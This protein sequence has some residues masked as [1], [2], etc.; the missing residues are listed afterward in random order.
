MN[1]SVIISASKIKTL[2]NDRFSRK[3]IEQRNALTSRI[4]DATKTMVGFPEPLEAEPSEEQVKEYNAKCATFRK[5][6]RTRLTAFN[7]IDDEIKTL[8]E[9]LEKSDDDSAKEKIK[10]SIQ[11]QEKLRQ[12]L[13]N[14]VSVEVR[15]TEKKVFDL[16]SQR[17]AVASR[18]PHI[19]KN[20][21][22]VLSLFVGDIAQ[23]FFRNAIHNT[24]RAKRKTVTCEDMFGEDVD[25]IT[26]Y[27][28]FNSLEVFKRYRE[29]ASQEKKNSVARRKHSSLMSAYK[30]HLKTPG[31]PRVT[32]PSA[33]RANP[34]VYVREGETRPV[35]FVGDLGKLW[36]TVKNSTDGDWRCSADVKVA[37][38]HL[39]CDLV[40]RMLDS[41]K[42]VMDSRKMSTFKDN[43]VVYLLDVVCTFHGIDITGFKSYIN[44]FEQ[45]SDKV[46][47]DDGDDDLDE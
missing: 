23:D 4:E 24:E 1:S 13:E 45:K 16:Y 29:A 38:S 19:G 21:P 10:K 20:F 26:Y 11:V 37:L 17:K 5:D 32:K 33:F 40:V 2:V 35:S 44:S 39:C 28:L 31:S 12:E 25:N 15:A 3:E 22:A 8:K 14:E 6:V 43:H 47:E 46:K 34:V 27:P 18:I 9:K 7:K 30:K 36:N 41:L 42:L